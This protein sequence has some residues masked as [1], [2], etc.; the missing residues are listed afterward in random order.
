MDNRATA[1]A[2]V[3]NNPLEE[4][5]QALTAIQRRAVD[6]ESGALLV[7]AGPRSGKTQVLTCRIARLLSSSPERRFRILAL[8]FTNK[9]ANEI[10]AR[11]ETLVPAMAARATIGTFHVFCTQIL[12]QHGVHLGIKPDFVIFSLTKDRQAILEDALRRDGMLDRDRRSLRLLPVIDHLKARLVESDIV[13]AH[14]DAM[15][16]SAAGDAS[17]VAHAYR[18]Y[19]DELRRANALDFNSLI[20]D[21]YRLFAFPAIARQYQRVYR[22]WLID[23]FQDT[24]SA[25]YALLRRMAGERFRD[26]VS[27]ADDDQAIFEWNSANA[28]RIADLVRDFS[29]D[30]V[31]L[32]TN[33]RC[34]PHIVEA[35]NRLVVYNTRRITSKRSAVSVAGSASALSAEQIRYL[36]FATDSEEA[37]GVANEIAGLDVAA[38]SETAVLAR[39]RSLL[40]AMH[41]AL[42]TKRVSA[43]IVMRRDEF[44]SAQMRWLMACLRQVVRPLDQRNMVA[45]V[46]AFNDFGGAA[47]DWEELVSRSESHE[48]TCLEAWLDMVREVEL[49]GSVAGVVGHIADLAGGKAKLPVAVEH[50]IGCFREGGLEDNLLNDDLNAWRRIQREIKDSPGVSSLDRL[51]QDLELRSKEPVPPPGT[52][53]LSTIHGAK[54]QQF[55]TVYLIGLAE[56]VLPS[57]QSLKNGDRSAALEEER[58]GCFVAVTRTKKRLILSRARQ[59]RGWP[60]QPSRFL[61]EMG[62]Q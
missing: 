29:C 27:V 11:V 42:T 40:E 44:S 53:S 62:I 45:L 4:A 9:A 3:T 47:V 30:V 56:E 15:N 41:R 28:H 7:L 52:V 51:L 36:E 54:G 32:P 2:D 34:P 22:H 6:W 1:G 18:L 58:R 55:D 46:D 8:T 33:F 37:A 19:E 57:W 39:S 10:A 49:P 13:E 35:A 48:I 16:G 61:K 25:Q 24:N 26:V 17:D 12:R 23:E 43:M 38:R 5:L 31:Q 60:K 20:L 21:T 50:I 14:V 59:Y